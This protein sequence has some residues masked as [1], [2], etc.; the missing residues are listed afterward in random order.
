MTTR[1]PDRSAD[2]R[3]GA[4]DLG[5][6]RP[7]GVTLE[8]GFVW[9][10]TTSAGSMSQID[11]VRTLAS[12]GVVPT[13][14]GRRISRPGSHS[15]GLGVGCGRERS[16]CAADRSRDGEAGETYQVDAGAA[17]LRWSWLGV[18]RRVRPGASPGSIRGLRRISS[19]S[20]SATVL[21]RSQWGRLC[22]GREQS[23]TARC[24]GSI[25][26]RNG[27]VWRDRGWRRAGTGAVAWA[28]TVVGWS[29]ERGERHGVADRP[30]QNR[31]VQTVSTGN[32]P[33]GIGLSGERGVLAVRTAGRSSSRWHV[34]VV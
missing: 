7:S 16:Q 23:S 28:G 6:E 17:G 11:P 14:H 26:C 24:R 4:D 2:E 13:I 19:R 31:V 21:P 33:E 25:R 12:G 30:A 18:G 22:L 34:S 27:Q 3:S 15:A 9:V 8:V 10:R 1:S 29:C 32:H 5:R 20:T